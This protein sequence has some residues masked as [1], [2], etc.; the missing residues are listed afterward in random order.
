[1]TNPSTVK[2]ART[3]GERRGDAPEG[4]E[5]DRVVHYV[6]IPRTEEELIAS[7]PPLNARLG[8]TKNSEAF[9]VKD[10]GF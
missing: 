7:K 5:D 9:D 4:T 2:S 1:M 6:A 10:T 3:S 8:I